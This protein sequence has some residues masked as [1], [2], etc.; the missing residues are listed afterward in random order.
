MISEALGVAAELGIADSLSDRNER[1]SADGMA[2]D[3]ILKSGDLGKQPFTTYF[4]DVVY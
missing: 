4:R 2:E 3:D 1:Q